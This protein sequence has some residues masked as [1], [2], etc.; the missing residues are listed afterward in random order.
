MKFTEEQYQ[1][2]VEM[3]EKVNDEY[4]MGFLNPNI[5]TFFQDKLYKEFG[6]VLYFV[7]DWQTIT[8]FANPLTREWAHDKFVEKEKK[9]YWNSI[10][11]NS[12]GHHS[13]LFKVESGNVTSYSRAEPADNISE[14]EQLTESEIREWGYNPDM[15]DREEVQ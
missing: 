11:T 1:T 2:I 15:F 6:N 9:Y 13:R 3:F 7:E 14:D 5:V 10:K 4:N 12:S 8:A